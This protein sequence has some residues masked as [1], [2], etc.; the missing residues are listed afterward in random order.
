MINEIARR[1]KPV[2]AYY[3]IPQRRIYMVLY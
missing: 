1:T 3:I 2:T